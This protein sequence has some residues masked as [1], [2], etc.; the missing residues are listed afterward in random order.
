MGTSESDDSI[1]I[2]INYRRSDTAPYARD[3]R[4]TLQRRYGDEAAFHDIQ[5][6]ELGADFT[7]A[8]RE[9]I[10][11]CD[12]F[13]CLIGRNWLS[14]EGRTGRPRLHEAEDPV[15]IEIREAL[16]RHELTMVPILLEDQ[17]MPDARD[18]PEALTPLAHRNALKMSD[19]RWE[20]DL[21]RLTNFIDGLVEKKRRE[22]SVGTAASHPLSDVHQDAG[23][24]L[25]PNIDRSHRPMAGSEI[26]DRFQR[27]A[28]PPR[29]IG[30]NGGLS[31]KLFQEDL[32]TGRWR[33]WTYQVS[34]SKAEPPRN[35]F[36]LAHFIR[37]LEQANQ[38]R[39]EQ[40][41]AEKDPALDSPILVTT[42]ERRR[43]GSARNY[44]LAYHLAKMSAAS[45]ALFEPLRGEILAL[46][47]DVF[48]RFM[49]QFIGYGRRGGKDFTEIVGK[50]NGLNVFIDGPVNDVMRIGVDVSNRGHWGS[51][52][53]RVRV[54]SEKDIDAVLP[55]IKQAYELQSLNQAPAT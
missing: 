47:D 51:G 8:I 34:Y 24:V 45:Q 39:L 6:V 49:N 2:F 17:R 43:Q 25:R 31:G 36:P 13:L 46:G 33:F 55:L 30:R 10:Q 27:A 44:D 16:D 14:D 26:V 52:D 35:W 32:S 19:E 7:V 28:D 9:A 22:S 21:G 48:E 41:T 1:R 37:A 50:R 3:L 42:S 18:L 20:Y 53:L 12:L 4:H 29:L 54:A 23:N 11:R 38:L 40:K 15:H 5:A